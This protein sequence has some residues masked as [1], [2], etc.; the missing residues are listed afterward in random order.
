MAYDSAYAKRK[1]D[2]DT[3]QILPGVSEAQDTIYRPEN[4][5]PTK[6]T[7][8]DPTSFTEPNTGTSIS[9]GKRSP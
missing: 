3:T 6:T 1:N 7:V 5:E 8:A 9:K 4:P 2:Y